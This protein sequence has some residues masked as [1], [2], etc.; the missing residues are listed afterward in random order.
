MKL[1]TRL[2]K[3]KWN[4]RLQTIVGDG[5]ADQNTISWVLAKEK[6]EFDLRASGNQTMRVIAQE[7]FPLKA[8]LTHIQAPDN[9][10]PFVTENTN[11]SG[12]R[13][14]VVYAEPIYDQYNNL[15]YWHHHVVVNNS[16]RIDE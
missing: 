14:E 12:T 6:V 15:A 4:A 1:F 3:L 2:N 9:T 5:P 11:S 13:L 8:L 7:R 16:G 10:R